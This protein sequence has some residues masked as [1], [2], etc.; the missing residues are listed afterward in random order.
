MQRFAQSP[1][2]TSQPDVRKFSERVEEGLTF[3]G[4]SEAISR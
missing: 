1:G 2:K 4:A 3:Y